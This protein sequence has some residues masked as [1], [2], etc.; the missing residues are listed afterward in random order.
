MKRFFMKISSSKFQFLG[1][2]IIKVRHF[3]ASTFV[4]DN[5]GKGYCNLNHRFKLSETIKAY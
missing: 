2:N 4:L 1:K 3:M 5:L